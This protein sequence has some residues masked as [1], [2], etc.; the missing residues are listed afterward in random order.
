MFPSMSSP[1][2]F[3]ALHATHGGIWIAERDGRVRE[4]GRGEAIAH[5]AESPTIL[6]NA[7]L[8]A[9]R[10]GYG[11]LSG[12]DLLE[13]FAFVHPA[14]FA[15]PTPAGM[16]RA[17]GLA[18]P[19]DD[20]AAAAF[21]LQAAEALLARVEAPGWGGARRRVELGAGADAA[22]LALGGGARPAADPAGAGRALAVLAPA[23]MGG[24]TRAAAAQA[25]GAGAGRDDE[26]A[27]T[28]GR[29]GR[30]AARRAARLCC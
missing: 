11:E 12:L 24:G 29:P 10:L 22:A 16:A 2:P 28:A 15:V 20:G 6:L 3:A 23:G 1:L 30:R 18:P 17:L 25:R 13:L 5:A 8:V 27:G 21:L 4:I 14:Q 7:P 9:T 26:S 19:A